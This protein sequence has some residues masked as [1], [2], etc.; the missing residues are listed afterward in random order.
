AC[1][2]KPLRRPAAGLDLRHCSGTLSAGAPRSVRLQQHRHVTALEPRTDFHI[3]HILQ[4]FKY[5]QQEL[6]AD[7]GVRD[8][9]ATEEHR[10]LHAL[11]ALEKAPR[12]IHLE[13]DVVDVG[14]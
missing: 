12:V 7:L 5:S 8:L 11:S 6:A 13:I 2:P 3:A 4:F 1:L 10:D 14:A 9:A